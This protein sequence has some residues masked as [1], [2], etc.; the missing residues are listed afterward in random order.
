MGLPKM[1]KAL[2]C[3]CPLWTRAFALRV[4]ICLENTYLGE[5]KKVKE[6]VLFVPYYSA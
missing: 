5:G 4:M 1:R 3:L 2:L 6:S